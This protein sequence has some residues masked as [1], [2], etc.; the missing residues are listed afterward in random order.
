MEQIRPFSG[1]GADP[2]GQ[3]KFAQSAIGENP[4]PR[5]EKHCRINEIREILNVSDRTARRL[6]YDE[7]GIRF[8]PQ[9]ASRT[10]RR[11][12]TAL[13]PESV[14]LRL[15]AAWETNHAAPGKR[16]PV[17]ARTRR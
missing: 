15:L 1:A 10:K 12:R 6:I 17:I 16:A 13:V 5:I 3:P 7:E 14:L 2:D 4:G 9:R 8:L 11:Y